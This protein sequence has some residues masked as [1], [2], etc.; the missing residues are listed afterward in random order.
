MPI[1]QLTICP[2]TLAE[3]FSS[4]SPAALK[5]L[6]GGE[7]VSHIPSFPT[8]T[9]NTPE[10][11]RLATGNIGRLSLS[12][13]QNKEGMVV[14]EGALRYSNKGE[15]SWYI[16]KTRP[17]AIHILNPDFC[18]AN[19]HLTMQIASQV[20]KLETAYNG[21]C[22][23]NDGEPAYLTR[24]FDVHAGGKYSQE[25]FASLMGFTDA[26]GG[27]DYKY[28]N[29]SYEECAEVIRKYVKAAII[30]VLAFFR[31]VLFNFIT[32]NDDAHLKNFSLIN[33]DGE[34]RLTP[35]YDLL[36]TSLHMADPRIFALDNGLFREGMAVGDVNSV[37]GKEFREFGRRIGL[38]DRIV[39]TVIEEFAAPNPNAE[40]LIARS[41]LSDDLKDF[42]CRSFR[43]RQSMLRPD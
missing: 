21:L 1:P 15:Q 25:D 4:Y 10:A 40:A 16:L 30:D 23:F 29:G 38:P 28:I 33:R 42:Y 13:A 43:H 20:Y 35:A 12:G 36:N 22:F 18:A 34:Y 11:K 26:N 2:S 37:S 27:K 24:R 31:L 7:A 9:E 17:T 5:N 19:E 14:E 6:F 39:N 8:P 41:F 3:G 32:L